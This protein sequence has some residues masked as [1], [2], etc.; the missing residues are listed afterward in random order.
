M[1]PGFVYVLISPNSNFVKIG[2]TERPISGRLRDINGTSQWDH[3]P[4]T[5]VRQ[6]RS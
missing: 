1:A 4:W 6:F 2:G 5:S 3:G